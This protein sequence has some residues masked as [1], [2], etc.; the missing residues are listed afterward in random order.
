MAST[1]CIGGKV[2][3]FQI[4]LGGIDARLAPAFRIR[5]SAR[6]SFRGR[7]DKA[8]PDPISSGVFRV[9]NRESV[10]RGWLT[11][12]VFGLNC[13]TAAARGLTRPETRAHFFV[14]TA[15]YKCAYYGLR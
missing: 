5:G 10:F 1:R 2:L 9:Q 12:A 14:R 15:H 7:C 11:D 3:L 6:W 8:T 4:Y 13:G